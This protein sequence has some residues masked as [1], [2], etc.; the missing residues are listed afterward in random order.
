MHKISPGMA[1]NTAPQLIEE[2]LFIKL[3][4]AKTAVIRIETTDAFNLT[5]INIDLGCQAAH[6]PWDSS[7]QTIVTQNQQR[8]LRQA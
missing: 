2:R 3:R 4:R 6:R 5:A 8:Q 1:A 7:S